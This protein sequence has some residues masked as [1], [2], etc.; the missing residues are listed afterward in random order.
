MYRC[1]TPSGSRREVPVHLF[2]LSVPVEW[3]LISRGV[4]PAG[5]GTLT[6]FSRRLSMAASPS[7]TAATST[8]LKEPQIER[9]VQ[10]HVT[11]HYA[12][13]TTLWGAFLVRVDLPIFQNACFQPAPDQV[14]QTPVSYPMFDKAEHPVV[15][16]APEEVLEVRLQQ[17]FHLPA[18][19]GARC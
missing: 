16:Q 13:R 17:P 7:S 6:T 14:D 1:R 4:G 12:D 3:V 19:T 9:I 5:V 18:I 11:Q 15:A 8:S 2:P 10:I